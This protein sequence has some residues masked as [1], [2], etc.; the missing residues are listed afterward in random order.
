[1]MDTRCVR[2]LRQ[3]ERLGGVILS[4]WTKTLSNM[5]ITTERERAEVSVTSLKQGLMCSFTLK[6]QVDA[7]STGPANCCY[8]RRLEKL[9]F[10]AS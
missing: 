8:L 3:D 5:I 7:D 2:I 6:V 1:M 9:H 10:K 4:Y